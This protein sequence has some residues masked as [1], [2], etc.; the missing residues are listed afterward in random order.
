MIGKLR[1]QKWDH[2]IRGSLLLGI[3]QNVS[4]HS[5]LLDV[6]FV[7]F[8]SFRLAIV[9]S[10]FGSLITIVF[11]LG[12][13]KFSRNCYQ[14]DFY[15]LSIGFSIPFQTICF[16]QSLTLS[17]SNQFISYISIYNL[18]IWCQK[19]LKFSSRCNRNHKHVSWHMMHRYE[20]SDDHLEYIF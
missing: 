17:L 12:M 6:T 4:I 18:C 16:R 13:H 2:I 7:T 20:Q 9:L 5:F 3:Q 11:P 1:K 8:N 14:Y 15:H 19:Y 10:Q